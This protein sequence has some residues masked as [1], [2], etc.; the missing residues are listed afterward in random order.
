MKHILSRK[1]AP[2]EFYLFWGSWVVAILLFLGW[3]EVADVWRGALTAVGET[4]VDAGEALIKAGGGEPAPDPLL[5]EG[6]A[7]AVR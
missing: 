2:V 3:G 5:G 4:L 1:F 6:R 7:R